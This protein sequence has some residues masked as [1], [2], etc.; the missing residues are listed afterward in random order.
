MSLSR[1][2]YKC[3]NEDCSDNN[4]QVIQ[5]DESQ[6][7]EI[8]YCDCCYSPM[9]LMGEIISGS[10]TMSFRNSSPEQRK[11]MLMKRSKKHFTTSG[12]ADKKRDIGERYKKEVITK[13]KGEF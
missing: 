5:K 2:N 3:L 1:Y 7:N 10:L 8:E 4:F 13:I 6:R 11:Q 12:L 9:K